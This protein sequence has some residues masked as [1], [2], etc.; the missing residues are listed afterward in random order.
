VHICQRVGSD[1][2]RFTIER[3]DSNLLGLHVWGWG[4]WPQYRAYQIGPDGHIKLGV[5]LDCADDAEHHHILKS[6]VF[7][8]FREVPKT[9]TKP[10]L[11][12][13]TKRRT[14]GG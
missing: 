6:T 12:V 3:K 14:L 13:D 1:V 10:A 11:G 2:F 7:C 4:T 8:M 5:D 9:S